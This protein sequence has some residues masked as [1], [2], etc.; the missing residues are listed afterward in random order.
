MQ[1]LLFD[2]TINNRRRRCRVKDYFTVKKNLSKKKNKQT[3]KEIDFTW[4]SALET[5]SLVQRSEP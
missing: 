2:L 4:G 3:C 1:Q 5:A